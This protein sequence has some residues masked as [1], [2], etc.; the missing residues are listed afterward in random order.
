MSKPD[1]R[2]WISGEAK[3]QLLELKDRY[4][5][6]MKHILETLIR[7]CVEHDLMKPFEVS[8]HDAILNGLLEK[9]LIDTQKYMDLMDTPLSERSLDEHRD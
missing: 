7:V 4:H 1:S 3:A 6:T 8:L 9:G 2:Q 5:F